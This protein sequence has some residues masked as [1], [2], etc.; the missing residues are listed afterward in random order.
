MRNTL[1]TQPASKPG[2]WNLLRSA[3]LAVRTKFNATSLVNVSSV[4]RRIYASTREFRST[5][6]QRP[7]SESPSPEVPRRAVE[8]ERLRID[9]RHGRETGERHGGARF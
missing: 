4:C 9:T 5:R 6:E 3:F 7:R 2:S 1:L 8:V